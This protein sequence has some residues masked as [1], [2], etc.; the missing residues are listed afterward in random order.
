MALHCFASGH[1]FSN[2]HNELI[3]VCEKGGKLNKLEE[4]ET[5]KELKRSG[6]NLLNNLDA[7]YTTPFIRRFLQID[8]LDL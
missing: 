8:N 2:I 7:T 4:L 3:H 1:H 5:L 6:A